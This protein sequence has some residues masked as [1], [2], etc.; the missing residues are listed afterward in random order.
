MSGYSKPLVAAAIGAL[1]ILFGFTPDW[2][3]GAKECAGKEMRP[4]DICIGSGAYNYENI[5]AKDAEN[6]RN[7]KL[8]FSTIGGILIIGAIGFA[9]RTAAV[10]VQHAARRRKSAAERRAR[11]AQDKW[12]HPPDPGQLEE[13]SEE[14]QGGG[15][16]DLYT[17]ALCYKFASN[18][19]QDERW[20]RW[21]QVIKVNDTRSRLDH[22][23][24]DF[25]V[26]IYAEGNV[27]PMKIE[28]FTRNP[29]F[30]SQIVEFAL[31]AAQAKVYRALNGAGG[32]RLNPAE[33]SDTGRYEELGLIPRTE[34]RLTMDGFVRRERGEDRTLPWSQ[35]AK[36]TKVADLLVGPHAVITHRGGARDYFDIDT[37]TDLAAF[38]LAHAL[39]SRARRS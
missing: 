39:W 28:G 5:E 33:W 16:V 34:L 29:E 31:Q 2:G 21:D 12:L 3:A 13:R 27:E 4:G 37:I 19:G 15:R 22:G 38:Q 6:R 23:C 17:H 9:V 26:W 18:A 24:P 10:D 8:I 32:L 14:L 30:V 25:S 1:I 20:V 36:I 35:V 11:A 7:K